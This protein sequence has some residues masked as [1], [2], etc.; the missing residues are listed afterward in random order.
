MDPYEISTCERMV[1][2]IIWESEEDP[3]LA[4]V[5]NGVNQEFGK[6]WK[7]QTVSTFLARLVKKG[8]LSVY[9]KGRYS[10]YQPL[11]SKDEFKTSTVSENIRYFNQGNIGA[12]VCGLFDNMKLSKEDK[13][14]IKKK[15][16]ELD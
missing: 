14:R 13:E 8:Y 7:P 11:V 2:K 16:D 6:N 5:M 9:R 3:D 4:H 1:M 10:Y 15:I 12:F